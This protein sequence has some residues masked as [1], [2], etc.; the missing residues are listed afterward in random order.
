MNSSIKKLLT[1]I[2][3]LSDGPEDKK[4]IC[5]KLN[6]S[7]DELEVAIQDINQDLENNNFGFYIKSTSI[8]IDMHVVPEVLNSITEYVPE[9]ILKGLSAPAM[10]TLAVI[11]YEQPVTKLKISD[12]RGVDS[13]SSIKTLES[14]GLIEKAGELGLPGAAV[15]FKTTKFFEQK[16]GIGSIEEL[17]RI[18]A[19]FTEQEEE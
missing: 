9:S 10:E 2:L 4:Y 5:T 15:L 13:E 7:L 14:R 16:M 12:I 8:N 3:L 1:A 11:A 18:G 6:I 19:L 17:P